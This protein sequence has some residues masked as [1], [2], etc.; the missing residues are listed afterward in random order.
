[1][2][3]IIDIMNRL[4]VK[5]EK[6]G[7]LYK[8]ICPLHNDKGPSLV[9]YPASNSFCCFGH[10]TNSKNGY[11]TGDSIE[12]VAQYYHFSRKDAYRWIKDNFTL[13]VKSEAL[14]KIQSPKPLPPQLVTY[15]HNLLKESNQRDYFYSRGFT[16]N[17]IDYELWG[18]DGNRYTI[19]VWDW[20]P[21]NSDCLGVR[22]RK[23]HLDKS[24]SP[25][26]I[27]FKNSNPATIY[28][29]WYCKD[30]EIILGFAGEFDCARANQDGFPSFSLVN[31]VNGFNKFPDNWPKL[32]FPDAKYL[33]AVFDKKEEV[34]A[35]RLCRQWNKV[36]GSFTAKIFHWTTDNKDYCEFRDI[37]DRDYFKELVYKQLNIRL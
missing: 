28:G 15:W 26:Y 31:G 2:A 27:G 18:W 9:I 24:D 3:D 12:F 22:R 8:A 29:K 25:K 11:N 21:Q 36:K 23:S 35:G 13:N 1:M 20:E 19:P 17:I 14:I 16:D 7:N 6:S 33:I 37:F 30:Q 5:L 34:L 10:C 4:G 32:W